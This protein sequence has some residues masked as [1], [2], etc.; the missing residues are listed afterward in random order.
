MSENVETILAALV[1]S[2]ANGRD[3][4]GDPTYFAR[5]HPIDDNGD[6]VE[7]H[8]IYCIDGDVNLRLVA[9]NIANALN[10]K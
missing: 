10:Q 7:P 8:D 9:A 1:A 4:R 3:Y 2:L 6:P 5:S